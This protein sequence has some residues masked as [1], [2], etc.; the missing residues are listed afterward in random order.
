[1]HERSSLQGQ[2]PT[3]SKSRLSRLLRAMDYSWVVPLRFQRLKYTPSNI[4]RYVHY[5]TGA[6]AGALLLIH[7]ASSS[8]TGLASNSSMR[9]IS[10]PK[11]S[12]SLVYSISYFSVDHFKRRVLT[13]RGQKVLH[14]SSSLLRQTV[15]V[16]SLPINTSLHMTFLTCLSRAD[17]PFVFDFLNGVNTGVDFAEFT[18]FLL[19]EGYLV[20]GD[21]YVMDN[22]AVHLT[23]ETIRDL[24]VELEAAGVLRLP[25]SSSSILLPLILL[26]L[27]PLH[28]L[29]SS[30]RFSRFSS[31]ISLTSCSSAASSISRFAL[32]SFLRTRL[33]SIRASCASPT[34]SA[35]SERILTATGRCPSRSWRRCSPSLAPSSFATI[36]TVSPT[37]VA[38]IDKCS[39]RSVFEG[40]GVSVLGLRGSIFSFDGAQIGKAE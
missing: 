1:M 30:R 19:G 22:A 39:S 8:S 12:Q 10:S 40:S 2:P 34:S 23:E 16:N 3:V 9:F 4:S 5:C 6:Q 24:M 13:K 27:V 15:L 29:S 21:I 37:P 36:S 25:T 11:V 14:I 26:L 35:T 20:D 17:I 7:Q 38:A 18:R 31:F 33:N 32:S 28:R